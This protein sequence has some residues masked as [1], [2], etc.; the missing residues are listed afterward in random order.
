MKLPKRPRVRNP[1]PTPDLFTWADRQPRHALPI[2]P[3]H[4]PQTLALARR[5]RLPVAIAAIYAESGVRA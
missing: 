3:I 1:N 4:I 2:L 5:H